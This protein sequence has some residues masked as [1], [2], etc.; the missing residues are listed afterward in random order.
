MALIQPGRRPCE[1]RRLRRR[2]A[3]GKKPRPGEEAT[4]GH[5]EKASIRESRSKTSA[6]PTLRQP[7][8][9]LWPPELRGSTFRWSQPPGLRYF[10]CQPQETHTR[11]RGQEGEG[12]SRPHLPPP[13]APGCSRVSAGGDPSISQHP[14][15]PGTIGRS[16]QNPDFPQNCRL[17]RNQPNKC[18]TKARDAHLRICCVMF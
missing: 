1:E 9:G 10:V 17:E 2:H 4:R 12:V 14:P 6:E 7:D 3:Q 11:G 5:T 18:P 15:A 8:L 16:K 13:Q